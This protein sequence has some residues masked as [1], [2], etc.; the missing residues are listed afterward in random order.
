MHK[1]NT[2]QAET[3]KPARGGLCWVLHRQPQPSGN[4]Y[5]VRAQISHSCAQKRRFQQSVRRQSGRTDFFNKIGRSPL[6]VTTACAGQVECKRVI[7]TNAIDWS[8]TMQMVKSM[9]LRRLT[10]KPDERPPDHAKLPDSKVFQRYR[11]AQQSPP[12]Y[13]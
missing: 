8:V 6:V 11:L 12:K 1:D 4:L 2:R 13:C 3:A 10:L 5:L 7:S 9:Q